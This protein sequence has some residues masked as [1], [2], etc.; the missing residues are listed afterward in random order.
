MEGNLNT[1]LP[2]L[3]L[4]I[5]FLNFV[6]LTAAAGVALYYALQAKRQADKTHELV[7]LGKREYIPSV[8]IRRVGT[9]YEYDR[10]ITIKVTEAVSRRGPLYPPPTQRVSVRLLFYFEGDY[11]RVPIEFVNLSK[12]VSIFGV[13]SS[14]YYVPGNN[15]EI[16]LTPTV[17]GLFFS[18]HQNMTLLPQEIWSTYL[19]FG[20]EEIAKESGGNGTYIRHLVKGLK[21]GKLRFEFHIK[22]SLRNGRAREFI[23]RYYAGASINH[24]TRWGIPVLTGEWILAGRDIIDDSRTAKEGGDV[25]GALP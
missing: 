20:V 11:A 19:E 21:E 6:A 22:Y 3:G 16:D 15:R 2:A 14:I 24:N 12:G 5:Q 4:I 23:V 18:G 8:S 13:S 25:F 17:K 7:I 9:S 1:V 10:A